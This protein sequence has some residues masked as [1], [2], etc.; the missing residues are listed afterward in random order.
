MPFPGVLPCVVNK[1]ASVPTAVAPPRVAVE[2]GP[3]NNRGTTP[4]SG[5]RSLRLQR[6]RRENVTGG[7]ESL[8]LETD[9]GPLTARFHP[10]P[11]RPGAKPRAVVWVAGAGGG[12]EGPARGLYPA[13]CAE[14]QRAGIAGLRLAYRRPNDLPPC[15]LDTMLGAAFLATEGYDRIAL[16]G[17]SFGGAVVISAGAL[18]GHVTAVVPLSTQTH[19]A[20]LVGE[21][22]PRPLLVVHGTEDEVLPAQC[23]EIVYAAARDPKELKL[24]ARARHGLDEVRD[25]V[26]ALLVDWLKRNT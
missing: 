18:S 16:V 12:W 25:E 4:A 5:P 3:E 1:P 17:H 14:L 11:A 13:A 21:V 26:L 2:I 10:V 20:E 22:S 19:G 23:S 15:V 7:V 8:T 24:F 6:V 9:D